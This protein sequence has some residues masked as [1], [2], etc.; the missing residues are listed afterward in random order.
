M[1]SAQRSHA[2]PAVVFTLFVM[3]GCDFATNSE[4]PTFSDELAGTWEGTGGGL[5]IEV[6]LQ[7]APCEGFDCWGALS[8]IW[9]FLP[10][11]EDGVFAGSYGFGR[12][13]GF[14]VGENVLMNFY[15]QGS[16]VG[17]HYDATILSRNKLLGPL[18]QVGYPAEV[19]TSGAFPSFATD[20]FT[21]TRR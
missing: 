21:F 4:L 18:T 5:T 7:A 16:D 9:A 20:S 10:S 3:A 15:D 13:P 6:Q 17:L 11:G 8:G 1:F 19:S 2:I 14:R 12:I